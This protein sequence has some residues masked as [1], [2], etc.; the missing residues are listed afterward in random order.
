MVEKLYQYA[1]YNICCIY[2]RKQYLGD[3]LSFLR[4]TLL[5]VVLTSLSHLIQ[6]PHFYIPIDKLISESLPLP[7]AFSRN[8]HQIKTKQKR[9]LWRTHLKLLQEFPPPLHPKKLRMRL[10]YIGFWTSGIICPGFQSHRGY[11]AC[12]LHCLH[13]IDSPDST[14]VRHLLTSCFPE[15][16]PSRFIHV[17]TQLYVNIAWTQTVITSSPWRISA[18]EQ[19][20]FKYINIHI[21]LFP[22]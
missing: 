15:W 18:W 5:W 2:I 16:Q 22:T 14:L 1:C 10:R 9:S 4:W 12:M 19:N 6:A 13:A 8:F 3:S 17:L 20:C 21:I 7:Q 11:S